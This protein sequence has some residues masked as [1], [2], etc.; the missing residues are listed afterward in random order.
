MYKKKLLKNWT[1]SHL[2]DCPWYLD[3]PKDNIF[4]YKWEFRKKLDLSY[5]ECLASFEME[6]RA[7]DK[8]KN[9]DGAKKKGKGRVSDSNVEGEDSRV[10]E[11]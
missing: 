8:K 11:H 10:L 9:Q 3:F 4:P 1:S 2:W 6:A 5:V 7:S